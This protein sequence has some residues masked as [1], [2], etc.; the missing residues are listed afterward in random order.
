[1]TGNDS[2]RY[3]STTM[4]GDDSNRC[5]AMVLRGDVTR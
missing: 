2:T 4:H 1:M 5:Y 3:R